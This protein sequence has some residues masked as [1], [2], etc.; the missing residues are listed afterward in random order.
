MKNE[1]KNIC[2]DPNLE[3]DCPGCTDLRD[4]PLGG[5][6]AGCTKQHGHIGC[7]FDKKAEVKCHTDKGAYE[8]KDEP[9]EAPDILDDKEFGEEELPTPKVLNW[10]RSIDVI[11]ENGDEEIDIQVK[12]L[13]H[14]LLADS[15]SQVVEKEKIRIKNIFN[16]ELAE[17]KLRGILTPTG[18]QIYKVLEEIRNTF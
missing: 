15:R 14:Q 16:K 11:L 2:P 13:I 8:N 5:T 1:I 3:G 18:E 17:I 9:P 10:E 6:H 7:E 4:D 12:D